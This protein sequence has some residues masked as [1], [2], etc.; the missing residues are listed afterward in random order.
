MMESPPRDRTAIIDGST[1]GGDI[2]RFRNARCSA[3]G[4]IPDTTM[5]ISLEKDVRTAELPAL[6]GGTSGR[7]IQHPVSN[8]RLLIRTLR[9]GA[10]KGVSI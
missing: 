6:F 5:A 7:F 8:G 3:A 4:R 1:A 9:H 10:G 2:V